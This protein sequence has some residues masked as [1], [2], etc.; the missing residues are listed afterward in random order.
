MMLRRK[1]HKENDAF[2]D[3]NRASFNT[4]QRKCVVDAA[5]IPFLG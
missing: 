2:L 3:I 1:R 5:K 4:E